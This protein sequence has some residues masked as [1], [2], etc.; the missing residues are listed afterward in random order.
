MA[1]TRP[2]VM[3]VGASSAQE[4]LAACI[5]G[6]VSM[7]GIFVPDMFQQ[8]YPYGFL[9]VIINFFHCACNLFSLVACGQLVMK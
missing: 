6:V 4:R 1:A 7:C 5:A 9:V 8:G 2:T 3:G